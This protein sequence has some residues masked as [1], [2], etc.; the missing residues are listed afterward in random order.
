MDFLSI[1]STILNLR[2]YTHLKAT[3]FPEDSA[4]GK[5]E[6]MS[7]EVYNENDDVLYKSDDI[8]Y[9]TKAFTIDV[10]ISGCEKVGIRVTGG[11]PRVGVVHARFE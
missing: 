7:L 2:N 8:R 1:V 3:V 9:D 10:D 6:V 4:W 11:W 5:G